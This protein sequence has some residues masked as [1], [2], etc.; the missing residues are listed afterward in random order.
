VDEQVV[1]VQAGPVDEQAATAEAIAAALD[2]ALVAR[3]A[4]Q[5]PAQGVQLLGASGGHL[6]RAAAATGHPQ[7]HRGYHNK[8]E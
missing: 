5:A 8:V 7:V 6:R 3:L 2:P 4:A 1:P